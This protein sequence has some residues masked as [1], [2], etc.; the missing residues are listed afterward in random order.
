MLGINCPTH[1]PYQPYLLALPY[2]LYQP[3]L[4]TLTSVIPSVP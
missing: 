4:P 1:L 3:Y 2:Q